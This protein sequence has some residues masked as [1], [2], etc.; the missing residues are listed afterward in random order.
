MLSSL[1]SFLFVLSFAQEKIQVKSFS[2]QGYVKSVE[3]I[4]IEFAHPM[5]QL[6]DIR[7]TAPA[8][9][10][11]FKNG[12]GRWIDTRNWVFDYKEALGGG[13]LCSV[14]VGDKTFSFNTGGAHVTE[15]F[16]SIYRNIEP[17]QNFVLVLDTPIKSESVAEGIYFVVDGLG[18]R[19]PAKLLT[20]SEASQVREAAEQEH[21]YQREAFQKEL[22]VIKAQ[23]PF[24]AGAK[25]TMVWSTKVLSAKGLASPANENFEFTVVRPFAAELGC[26]R[27]GPNKPCVP[28]MDMY[29]SFN[30]EISATDAKKIFLETADKKKIYAKDLEEK[31]D[32]DTLGSLYFKGPFAPNAT[33]QVIIPKGLKDSDGRALSN[34]NKFPLGVKTGENPVLLK[35]AANFGIVEAGPEAAVAVT[36][37]RVEKSLQTQFFGWTGQLTAANFKQ[38][39]ESLNEVNVNSYGSERSKVFA[40]LN[41][42]QIKIEKPGK[43]TDTEVVG[44][45]LKEKGFYILEMESPLLGQGLLDKKAPYYVRTAALVT[46]MALHIKYTDKEAWVWATELKSAK[47]IPGATV[48]IYNLKGDKVVQGTTDS[49]GLVY[50]RFA[51]PHEDWPKDDSR[52]F[53]G[54]F[55]AVAEKNND[56]TFTHTSWNQGIE[57]WRYQLGYASRE[58]YLGHAILDRTLFKP[59][60]TLSAKIILRKDEAQGLS[61]PTGQSW[62]STLTITHDSGL[63]S[64][65][66]PLTWNKATG[67]ALV[68]WPLPTGAKLGNWSLSLVKDK[69]AMLI[70]VGNFSV[71]NFRVPLVQVRVSSPKPSFVLDSTVPVQVTGTYFS[72]GPTVDLPMKLRWSVEANYFSPENDDFNDFTFANGGV[73]EGVFRSGEDEGARYIPQSGVVDFKLN[74]SGAATVDLSKLKYGASPQ[75]LRAEVEYKDPNGEIQSSIRSFAMWPSQVVLGIKS[76]SW[77]AKQELVEFETIALDVLQRPLKNQKIQVDL[78]TSRY[79]SHRKRLV[80]GFYA[81]EDFREY[82][83]VGKLCEGVTNDK[84]L[85]SCVGSAKVSGSVLAIVSSKDSQGRQAMANVS[86][87]ITKT[88]ESQWFGSGDNDRTDLIPF[89]KT[90]EPGEVAE[91]QLR[92]PFPEAK[93][94]VTVERNGVLWSEVVDVK[95][96]NPVIRVPIKKEYAPNVVISAFAIRGRLSEPKATALID[97]G[98]PAFKMG[99]ANVKVGWKEHT[100]K[101]TVSSDR[102]K[103]RAREKSLVLVSVKDSKGKPALKGEV[104]LIAVDEGLLEIRDNNSWEVLPRMMRARAHTVETATAQ[105]LVIGKRHFGLKAVAAGGDGGGVLRRELFDTLLYWNPSV[106][107]DNKGEARVEIPLNDST[108]SFRIVAVAQQGSEQFGTGWTSIQ[109]SQELTILPGLSGV[110]REGDE[111]LAGFTLRNASEE[112]QNLTVRLDVTPN[113]GEMKAQNLQLNSGEAKE[114]FWKVKVPAGTSLSY[115]VRASNDKGK[116]LDEVKK[117]QRIIPLR[118]P[119]IY[120]SEWGQWPDFK[121]ISL[122][123][124]QTADKEESSV[125]LEVSAGLGGSATGIKDFWNNYDFNCLEQ[126]VSRA[127]SLNDK[128]AWEKIENKLGVYIDEND[129][130]KYFPNSQSDGDVALTAYVLSIAHEAGFSFSE[131]NEGKLLGGLQQYAEGK[132]KEKNTFNRAD[133]S[134]K[135]IS[136]FESLSRYRRL[137]TGLLSTVDYQGANWPLYALV[138]WYQIHLW[139]KNIP[140]REK[141][142]ANVEAQL[143]NRFY[144]TAK[145]LQLRSEE[146]ERMSWLMRGPESSLLRLIGATLGVPSWKT[147]VPRLYQGVLA[148]QHQGSWLVTADN[149]W[150]SVIMRKVKA[151]YSP[152]KVQ[153]V[154]GATLGSQTASYDFAKGPEGAMEIPWKQSESN[155]VFTHQGSG[156]PWITTSYKTAVPVTK[157]TFAGFHVQKKITPIEQKT[158]GVWSVGDT[159]TVQLKVS[160]KTGQSWVVIED[161]IPTGASILTNTWATAVERKEELIRFYL[162]WFEGPETVIEYTIRFNQVGNYLLPALRVEAM[163][164]PDIFAE[165]PE[166]TWTVQ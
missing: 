34:E 10:P 48:S 43:A 146:R 91:L 31:S 16:P 77:Y 158:K 103:Y 38:I 90:Y 5:V 36:M 124:P 119:R 11:C 37:R 66:V 111:F 63:Q 129:L 42:K 84:G 28:L 60:E 30:A 79:Y 147:D 152:E 78:Y 150:G 141:A 116:A 165:L 121:A 19:I 164:S 57:P 21:R 65:K 122:K 49:R 89:K 75:R 72:G 69:P 47:V 96:E 113:I 120:Q 2:P 144:F 97:L 135:K 131:E 6:G 110:V 24:P 149:A 156:K 101:V 45:P 88:G 82:K 32:K 127:I 64:F 12:A 123:Q 13:E 3:Q 71:E 151:A 4:R 1:F 155:L 159:A 109:S 74:S 40:K 136:A 133:E 8:T 105:S 76:K 23:R 161:P 157:E 115:V 22:I 58:A 53:Y 86:Q 67:V 154:F 163:Y 14:T 134:L 162:N 17:E 106:K 94:L 80:G 56:F 132:L 73:K 139:E 160:A 70:D 59:E 62:P 35:F 25:V 117:N 85:F 92:T 68:R 143:R 126:Q 98:K 104:A 41:R 81:Y 102:K 61:L 108:T 83:K 137:D 125:V 118:T 15:V 7:L 100:L 51:K 50:F 153:G 112:K 145:K 138:E 130:L 39:L 140:G 52:S 99:M 27:E 95:G 29:L 26:Q 20:G 114:V 148:R 87:W 9:S 33:F 166:S 142:L 93:V 107:L 55:F 18:D 46:D 128:K 54:G 44:I